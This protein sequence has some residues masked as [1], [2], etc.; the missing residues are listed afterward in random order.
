MLVMT[1]RRPQTIPTRIPAERAE[2]EDVRPLRER[3]ADQIPGRWA[4]LGIV[5]LVGANVAAGLLEPLPADPNQPEPWFVTLPTT[6]A[7]LAMLAALGGLL[8][9]RR[10]GMG[11]SLFAAGVAVAM[12]LAC[13]IS[14]HHRFGLWWVGEIACVGAWAGVSFAGMRCRR[15]SA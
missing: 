11:L 12:V 3:F 15:A 10:W 7:I 6:V 5:A 14:G 8:V 4:L 13:P 2:P 1:P 9:R